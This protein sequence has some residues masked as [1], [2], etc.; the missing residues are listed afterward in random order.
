[1]NKNIYELSI[2]EENKIHLSKIEKRVSFLREKAEKYF[3]DLVIIKSDKIESAY[4]VNEDLISILK[5]NNNTVDLLKEESFNIRET[6]QTDFTR[7]VKLSILDDVTSST[8]INFDANIRDTLVKADEKMQALTR[9]KNY[10]KIRTTKRKA[11]MN[12][13]INNL[14]DRIENE[15]VLSIESMKE[16]VRLIKKFIDPKE[17]NKTRYLYFFILIPLVIIM[18]V[19]GGALIWIA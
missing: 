11:E 16:D 5:Q 13:A 1:M 2:S 17:I 15:S 8:D 3:D 10:I 19:I 4:S 14:E 6:H 7:E 12:L 9:R 18:T